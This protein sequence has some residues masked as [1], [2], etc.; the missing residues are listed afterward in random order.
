VARVT[1]GRRTAARWR[2]RPVTGIVGVPGDRSDFLIEQAGRVAAR[3]FR[4]VVI[5]E[6]EDLRGRRSGEVAEPLR[7]AVRDE[8]PGRECRIAFCETEAL[9]SELDT[10]L[11]RQ[12]GGRFVSKVGAEGLYAAGVLPCERWPSGLGLALKIEDGDR[13]DRARPVA[14]VALLSRL[15]VLDDADARAL[16]KFARST[17]KNRRGEGVGEVRPVDSPAQSS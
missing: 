7:R 14:A 3:G 11:I 9:R 5:K 15:G 12:G 1:R 6:D 16:G 10:E 13:Q 8:A 4:R 2:G 17:T